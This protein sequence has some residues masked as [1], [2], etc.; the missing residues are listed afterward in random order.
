MAF[1]DGLATRVR[2]IVGE[3]SGCSEKR[4]FGSLV[5]FL[6]GNMACGV[7]DDGLLVRLA[8]AD[9]EAGLGEPGTR[10]FELTGRPM[11]NWLVV[12]AA[13][14]AEDADL[15]RWVGRGLAFAGTLPPK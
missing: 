13:A 11:R 1:D 7:Q 9:R 3:R 8:P 2:E 12:D 14:V 4:M 6:D 5:F 10:P 15:R